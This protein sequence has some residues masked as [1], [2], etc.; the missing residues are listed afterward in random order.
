M[1]TMVRADLTEQQWKD[2]R[3][4]SIE[5]SVPVQQIIGGLIREYLVENGYEYVESTT[6]TGGTP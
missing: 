2:L 3:K 4:L 5:H 6:Q 1:A